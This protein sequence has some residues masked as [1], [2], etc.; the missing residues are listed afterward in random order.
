MSSGTQVDNLGPVVRWHL[1]ELWLDHEWVGH[2]NAW[3]KFVYQPRRSKNSRSTW[4]DPQL[5]ACG[6]NGI[7]SNLARACESDGASA[8]KIEPSFFFFSLIHSFM[9]GGIGSRAY[10]LATHQRSRRSSCDHRRSALKNEA[11]RKGDETK[12][13]MKRVQ[14]GRGHVGTTAWTTTWFSDVSSN[15]QHSRLCATHG[16]GRSGWTKH[17]IRDNKAEHSLEEMTPVSR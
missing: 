10:R 9:L 16:S 5:C 3:L 4:H 7:W 11:P 8:L 2:E 14:H 6:K 17:H 12:L 13:S 1:G 15:S